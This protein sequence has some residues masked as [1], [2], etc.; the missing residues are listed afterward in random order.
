MS[1][2]DPSNLPNGL[3]EAD[4]LDWIEADARTRAS[5]TPGS[6]LHRVGQAISADPG[7]ARALEAMRIDRAAMGSLETP[8]PPAWIAQS[9]LEEHERQAL[10]ALSDMASR[11]PRAARYEQDENF[12]ISAMPGWFKPAMA[13]AAVLALAFGAWQ[14]IPLVLPKPVPIPDT[15]ALQDDPPETIDPAPIQ[16]TPVVVEH[17]DPT[18]IITPR[19][20]VPSAA[21]LLASRLDMPVEDALALALDGRLMIVV[22][23]ANADHV[24]DAATAIAAQPVSSSWTLAEPTG[25]LLAAMSSPA[26]IRFLGIDPAES[27]PAIATNTGPLGQLEIVF[28][29]TPTVYV[30]RA[31]ASAEAMLSLLD[32]LGHLGGSCRI[33]TLDEPLPEAGAT[34]A[35]VSADALLWWEN[36]AAAWQ[37]WAAIPVRFIESR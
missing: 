32:G 2:F 10:L 7:L 24:S 14:L 34:A 25:E 23:S 8:A 21:E 1:R 11:G 22:D 5:A 37:P 13:V 28:A 16:D 33:V 4:L 15:V 31:S 3:T 18:P 35:P 9:I 20:I 17:V 36:D 29:S 30:A 12:S 6:A 19:A 27:G 26:H